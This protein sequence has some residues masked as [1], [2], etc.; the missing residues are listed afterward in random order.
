MCNRF[1]D[2]LFSCHIDM[3]KPIY[4]Q[5]RFLVQF[6]VQCSVSFH[7]V[8]IFYFLHTTINQRD[9]FDCLWT[10]F[11][12]QCC[13]VLSLLG[14]NGQEDIAFQIGKLWPLFMPYPRGEAHTF[15]CT[16]SKWGLKQY[17]DFRWF[18]QFSM[19]V[20]WPP[21]DYGQWFTNNQII[22]QSWISIRFKV[23]TQWN[24]WMGF[25]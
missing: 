10:T 23:S 13:T 18:P 5:V 21:L 8:F 6:D 16:Y 12:E 14:S 11:A 4:S 2:G 19:I 9:C 17:L 1:Y 3:A 20:K 7:L 24:L 15:Q 25:S 22:S